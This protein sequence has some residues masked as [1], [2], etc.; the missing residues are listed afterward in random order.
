MMRVIETI[1]CGYR[2]R[3]RLEARWA[4]YFDT[5]GLKWEYEKEGFRFK[6]DITYLPDFWLP[7]V[8]MWAEIK[9]EK[10]TPKELQKAKLLVLE[11]NYSCLLLEGVPEVKPYFY[12]SFLDYINDD[13]EMIDCAL[14]GCYLHEGR[15]FSS[16]GWDDTIFCFDDILPAV[17]AARS[18]RFEFENLADEN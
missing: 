2:F 14:S 3:S 6:N 7:Q 13:I 18:A 1:Y 11:S 9:P 10:F 4:V 8:R 16:L 17:E 12:L 5:I 15:F